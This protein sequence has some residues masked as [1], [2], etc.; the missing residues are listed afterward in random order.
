MTNKTVRIAVLTSNRPMRGKFICP[1]PSLR[2]GRA[3]PEDVHSPES[4]PNENEQSESREGDNSHPSLRRPRSRVQFVRS[5]LRVHTHGGVC[6]VLCS[7]ENGSL[8]SVR[9]R[10]SR[11]WQRHW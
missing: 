8:L 10:R 2:N 9:E 7:H 5:P 11:Q 3:S 1:C 4:T 6:S